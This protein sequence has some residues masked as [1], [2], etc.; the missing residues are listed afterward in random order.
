MICFLS[1]LLLFRVVTLIFKFHSATAPIR[2]FIKE[3]FFSF[4]ANSCSCKEK[5][6][7]NRVKMVIFAAYENFR[8][9]NLFILSSIQK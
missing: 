4:L 6:N 3:S 5:L 7:K 8:K 2:H 9:I 1:I